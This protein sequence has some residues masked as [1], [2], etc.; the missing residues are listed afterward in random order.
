[1]MISLNLL[2]AKP[3]R[4]PNDPNVSNIDGSE[5]VVQHAEGDD[6][7]SKELDDI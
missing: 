4:L 7:S 6:L 1:M 5:V 3:F 2:P